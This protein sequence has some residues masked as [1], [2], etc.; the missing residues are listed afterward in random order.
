VT[1]W[2]LSSS[3]S[4]DPGTLFSTFPILFTNFQL[5]F[6]FG[7]LSCSFQTGYFLGFVYFYCFSLL[8]PSCPS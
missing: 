7:T 2:S 3:L 6:I 1:I 8:Y 5:R 4:S